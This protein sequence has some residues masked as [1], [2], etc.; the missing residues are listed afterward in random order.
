MS[1]IQGLVFEGGGEKGNVGK[2]IGIVVG[3]FGSGGRVNCGIVGMA[4]VEHLLEAVLEL[5][6]KVEPFLEAMLE[7]LAKVA[8]LVLEVLV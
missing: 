7:L 2:V 1:F 5:L 8:M 6:A 3:K 4:K